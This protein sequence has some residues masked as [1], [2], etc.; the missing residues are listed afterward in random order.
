MAW[1]TFLSSESLMKRTL[2]ASDLADLS[3]GGPATPGGSNT[4]SRFAPTAA[5]G[6]AA[7]KRR[8]VDGKPAHQYQVPVL[9]VYDGHGQ[10]GHHI[11]QIVRDL[12]SLKLHDAATAA[13]AAGLTIDWP[14]ALSRAYVE[15]DKEVLELRGQ[16]KASGG[17]VLDSRFAGTTG[18]TA[19]LDGLQ[20]HIASVGNSPPALMSDVHEA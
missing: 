11:S 15:T 5:T 19:V 8:S 20:L 1:P 17:R 4:T 9:A 3:Q 7:Q 13:L 12:V 2:S 10:L 14:A 16:Q 6:E 18:T